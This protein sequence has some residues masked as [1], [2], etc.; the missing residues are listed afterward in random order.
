MAIR[1]G[2]ANG[3]QH[4][5]AR[6]TLAGRLEDGPVRKGNKLLFVQFLAA[7]THVTLSIFIWQNK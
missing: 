7:V 2:I 4:K 1:Y 3:S 6:Q 5:A